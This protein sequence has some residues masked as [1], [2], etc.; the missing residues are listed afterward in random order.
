V[1]E[2]RRV[3]DERK[4]ELDT[5]LAFIS[6]IEALATG[7]GR[8]AGGGRFDTDSINILKS[9]LLLHLYNVVE[10]VMSK[11]LE[12]IALAAQSHVPRKW[13]D[14][15]LQE[16]AIGRVNLTRDIL[17][18]NAET[19]IVKLLQEAVERS[20]VTQV[21]I[22]RR[23]GNWSD[24]EIAELAGALQCTLS[25]SDPVKLAAC[26]MH[27]E[28]RKAPMNYIRHMRNQL[29]HGNLSFVEGARH[30]SSARLQELCD[31]VINY[32]VEVVDAFDLY[33]DNQNFL[34]PQ[35]Q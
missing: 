29:A 18:Q 19:R 7:H 34:L 12:E 30:L 28:D 17:I 8:T 27:F 21:S 2:F 35:T 10:A 31:N 4:S 1:K 20:D 16:W 23:S 25:I 22:R 13:C 11:V 15:L 3:L 24:S 32:M 5:H 33:I 26:E 6:Q 14:G 9:G